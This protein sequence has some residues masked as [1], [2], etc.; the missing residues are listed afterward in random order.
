VKR[1]IA[2]AIAALVLLTGCGQPDLEP[3]SRE[4]ESA[5]LALPGVTGGTVGAGY[6]ELSP[7]I[8]CELTGS[9]SSK[10]ALAATLD[11]VLKT[12]ADHTRT[13]DD[14]SMVHCSIANGTLSVGVG[15]LGFDQPLFM[16]DLRQRYP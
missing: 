12:I 5:V 1:L 8:G 16:H 10:A 3:I 4:L 6:A 11:R 13:L 15:D 9:G 2:P 14:G 7:N